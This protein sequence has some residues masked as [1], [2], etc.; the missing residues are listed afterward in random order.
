MRINKYLAHKDICSRR[1]A[2]RLI[3]ENKVYINDRIAVLGDDVLEED[4]V[5]VRNNHKNYLYFAYHKP[6]GIITHSPQN[7]EISIH[8]IAKIPK[9]VFPIGRLDKDS[10][11]LILLTNDGRVIKRIL[12]PK[13]ELEKEYLVLLDKPITQRF[14]QQMM[15]GVIIDSGYKTKPCNVR[16]YDDYTIKI[17][18][19]EGK[20]RQIRRMAEALKYQVVE[21]MRI[22]IGN[23]SLDNL[24]PNEW[25]KLREI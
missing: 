6:K 9:E 1:E 24:Q 15:N 25:R 23:I 12:D 4:K 5:E 13:S 20:K 17:I 19:T 3:Q 21:L 16:K 2:D 22:R 14:I 8:N 18:L 7:D 11:G 10:S